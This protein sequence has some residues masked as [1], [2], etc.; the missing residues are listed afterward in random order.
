MYV[1]AGSPRVT[2][3]VG[4]ARVPWNVCRNVMANPFTFR[5]SSVS[6]IS[7]TSGPTTTQSFDF[8]A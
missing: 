8:G 5:V 1:H 6:S 3:W 4:D 2:V 7:S